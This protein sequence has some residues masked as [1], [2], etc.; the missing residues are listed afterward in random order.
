MVANKV[1]TPAGT[2]CSKYRCGERLARPA[3]MKYEGLPRFL[4]SALT[5]ALKL[6]PPDSARRDCCPL[7]SS[8]CRKSFFL[9]VGGVLGDEFEN[10]KQDV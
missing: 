5:R 8:N 2:L 1:R 4:R 7:N 6:K 3:W 9:T 10:A